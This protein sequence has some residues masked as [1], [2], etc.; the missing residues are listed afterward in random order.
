MQ[1]NRNFKYHDNILEITDGE[2]FKSVSF[3]YRIDEILYFENFCM[4]MIE[5][6]IGQTLNENIY[7]VSIDGD[8][9]WQ[10]A[11]IPHAYARSSYTGMG[12]VGD[13]VKLSNW[14]GTDLIINPATGDILEKSY[15][16]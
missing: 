3:R 1:N 5:P 15:S 10:I 16:K 11:P 6:G 9:L 7:G 12:K 13:K 14:D 4:V 8:I 2:N